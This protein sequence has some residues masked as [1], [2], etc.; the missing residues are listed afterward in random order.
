M[1]HVARANRGDEGRRVVAMS[2]IFHRVEVI[3]IAEELIEAMQRWQEFV[4]V[5]EMV[6]AELSR[7]IAHG[8]ERCGDS[9]RLR[10]HADLGTG[11]ADRG[12]SGADGK[13]AGDEVG[14]TRRT[15]RFGIV[16][17][18]PHSAGS[19][20]VEVR[21]LARHDA[22]VIGTDVVPTNVIAHDDDDVRL[23]CLRKSVARWERRN[24]C[25]R[26]SQ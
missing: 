3:E 6:F 12:Q 17:G 10:R 16:V 1:N 4:E 2:R 15:T 21:G 25:N 11:L 7:S 13:L 24:Q 14:A 9:R 5:A 19:Q 18:E 26:D 8:L 23:L 20:L 22:L